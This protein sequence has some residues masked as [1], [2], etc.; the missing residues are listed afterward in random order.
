MKDLRLLRK[1]IRY[2]YFPGYFIRMFVLTHLTSNVGYRKSVKIE[3]HLVHHELYNMDIL[4]EDHYTYR[5]D[6]RE[7]LPLRVAVAWAT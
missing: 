4:M 5:H 7:V 3:R 2:G 6:H 1:Y